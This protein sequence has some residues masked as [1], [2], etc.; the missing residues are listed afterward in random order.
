[1]KTKLIGNLIAKKTNEQGHIELTFSFD[2][3]RYDAYARELEKKEYSIELSEK[4]SK[5]TNQQNKYLWA[6]IHEIT[7]NENAPRH[8]DWEMYLYLLVLA[9]AKYC[10]VEVQE[11]AEEL[12]IGAV[13][14]CRKLY[15]T[16]KPDGRKMSV[17]QVFDGSSTMDTKQM[18]KLI[19]VTLNMASELG[20]DTTYYIDFLRD[21]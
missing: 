12:L 9:E 3:Y 1:M 10:I 2:N 13:R 6:L 15:Y 5:R 21:N 8:N 16:V 18:A 4:K 19:D 20:I 14:A 11:E 7:Q 17:I